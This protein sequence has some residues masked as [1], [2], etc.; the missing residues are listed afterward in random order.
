MDDKKVNYSVHNMCPRKS[1]VMSFLSPVH[2]SGAPHNN[3]KSCFDINKAKT[4][5]MMKNFIFYNLMS[6][7]I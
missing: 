2:P 1:L 5:D 6:F 4:Y 3:I 7:E